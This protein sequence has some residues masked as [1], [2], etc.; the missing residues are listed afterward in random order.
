MRRASGP[1]VEV[2]SHVAGERPSRLSTFLSGT[3]R[4]FS[5][6]AGSGLAGA[7]WTPFDDLVVAA[8]RQRDRAD[9]EAVAA[10]VAIHRC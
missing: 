9:R 1:H 8:E 2:S 4:Y 7:G 6:D 10:A 3:L 5:D